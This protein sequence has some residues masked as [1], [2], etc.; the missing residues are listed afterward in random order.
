QST[1]YRY[2]A[3]NVARCRGYRFLEQCE[4]ALKEAS[5]SRPA[6]GLCMRRLFNVLHTTIERPRQCCQ[7]ESCH[8]QDAFRSE[9]IHENCQKAQKDNCDL[10]DGCCVEEIHENFPEALQGERYEKEVFR[11][12]AY[13]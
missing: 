6:G 4:A 7:A 1:V 12:S 2:K 13:I 9:E 10:Q 8:L 3:N 5:C 11:C